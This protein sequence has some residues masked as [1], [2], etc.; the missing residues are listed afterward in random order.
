MCASYGLEPGFN[1]DEWV[2]HI[3]DG[4]LEALRDWA[5][6]NGG[7]VLK[8]TG[9]RARNLNPIFVSTEELTPGWWGY[10]QD[11]AAAKF[12]SI[13]SR[14][15]RLAQ[16]S[17]PLPKRAIVPASHWREFQQPSKTLHHLSDN[18]R[19]LGLAAVTRAGRTADGAEFT[20]YSLVMR[21]AAPQI[22]S[23]HDR[24]PLLI[25]P[26][27][28]DEWLESDA[29]AGALLAGAIAASQALSERITAAAQDA[30]ETLF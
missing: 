5:T 6:D 13:N 7:R 1:G 10:L 23:V 29:P 2:D 19:L 11:G 21:P 4:M 12:P 22:E 8:P 14:S 26:E 3:A 20:C 28:T 18:G 17:R 9:I 27:F 30:P 16:S 24:M 15:E 25:S